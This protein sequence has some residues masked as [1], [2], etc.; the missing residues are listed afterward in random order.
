MVFSCKKLF[1][2]IPEDY[3]YVLYISFVLRLRLSVVL[4][5][6]E[7]ILLFYF[8]NLLPGQVLPLFSYK[9]AKSRADEVVLC[10]NIISMNILCYFQCV[11]LDL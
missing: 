11:N 10:M 3:F 7:T 1:Y 9:R 6:L 2:S 4:N 8:V 5:T